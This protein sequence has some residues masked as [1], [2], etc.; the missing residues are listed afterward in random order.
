MTATQEA[1]SLPVQPNSDQES[2]LRSGDAKEELG[3][4]WHSGSGSRS[5]QAKAFTLSTVNNGS[6]Q[7]LSFLIIPS[8]LTFKWV[9]FRQSR[10]PSITW[11]G[12]IRSAEGLNRTQRLPEQGGMLQQTAVGLSGTRSSEGCVSS[13]GSQ[14]ATHNTDPGL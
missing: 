1:S 9:N 4:G 6:R 5:L 14:T 13:P 2:K 3:N 7:G 11:V 10:P 8:P 12:L